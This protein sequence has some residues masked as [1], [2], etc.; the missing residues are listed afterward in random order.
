[1][2]AHLA[3]VLARRRSR[4]AQDAVELEAIQIGCRRVAHA[5]RRGVGLPMGGCRCRDCE[6]DATPVQRHAVQ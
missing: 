6:R 3:D 4:H 2:H 1:M 5:A